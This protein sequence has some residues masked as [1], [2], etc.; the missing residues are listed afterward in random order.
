MYPV[1]LADIADAMLADKRHAAEARRRALVAARET[2]K[3]RRAGAGHAPAHSPV[4]QDP[5]TPH[6]AA[7]PAQTSEGERE[8]TGAAR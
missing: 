3:S 8:L 7:G 2:R 6:P 1:F 4:G 5:A